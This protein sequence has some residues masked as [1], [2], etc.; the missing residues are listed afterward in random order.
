MVQLGSSNQEEVE[1]A[2]EK[3]RLG[4][5]SGYISVAATTVEE[6][7]TRIAKRETS[8]AR[9]DQARLELS[10]RALWAHFAS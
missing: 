10:L 6:N 7:A 3:A 5:V 4:A 1:V 9:R 8:D 2:A